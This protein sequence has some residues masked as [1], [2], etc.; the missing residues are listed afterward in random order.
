MA[1][2]DEQTVEFYD[3]LYRDSNRLTSY[4]SQI[5]Q[6]R[7]ASIEELK[8]SRE[9]SQ[10]TGGSNLQVLSGQYQKTN[11]DQ[12]S[13]KRVFDPHDMN[14]T[15]VLSFLQTKNYIHTDYFKAPNGA[16]VLAKGKLFFTDRNLL[17]VSA[18]AVS[19]IA[20]QENPSHELTQEQILEANLVRQMLSD[21]FFQPIYFLQ[22]D[23]GHTITGT[24]K[25]LGLEEPIS[26]HYIKYGGWGLGGVYIIGVKE[27]P[28][29]LDEERFSPM[30]KATQELIENISSFLCGEESIKVTPL[31]IFRK[32]EPIK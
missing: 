17:S 19:L 26:S 1:H 20:Q 32:I 13:S 16:M 23:E 5:F 7:L 11:E 25:E 21:G 14:T 6:G 18:Q 8:N 28:E 12:T 4:Y 15:D 27:E 30:F 3:F 24:V 31:A 22:T 10:K 9:A 29:L 2:E